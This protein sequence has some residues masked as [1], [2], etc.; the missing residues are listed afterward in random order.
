MENGFDPDLKDLSAVIYSESTLFSKRINP[1]YY[2]WCKY[3]EINGFCNR[4]KDRQYTEPELS[5]P[6]ELQ[7]FCV[8]LN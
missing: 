7:L 2:N 5:L 1:R 8:C 3:K 4:S 6:A